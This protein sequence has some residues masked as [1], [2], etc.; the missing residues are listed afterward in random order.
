MIGLRGNRYRLG[1]L[2]DFQ[3][4]VL[5]LPR[6]GFQDDAGRFG[7]TEPRFARLQRVRA[8]AQGWEGVESAGVGVRL[9][10]VAGIGVSTEMATPGTM[11]PE[12]SNTLP[13]IWPTFVWA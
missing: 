3:G 9:L 12:I 7:G 5:G 1:E 13:E 10:R 4:E 8:A 11:A 6:R 2:P